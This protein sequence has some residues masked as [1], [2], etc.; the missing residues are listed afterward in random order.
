MKSKTEIMVSASHLNIEYN[1]HY[2]CTVEFRT[3]GAV[4]PLFTLNDGYHVASIERFTD[5]QKVAILKLYPPRYIQHLKEEFVGFYSR[6][7][8]RL[9]KITRDKINVE[10]FNGYYE[11]SC[12][13]YGKYY[14]Q[15]YS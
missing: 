1:G 6:F 11:L 13:Y 15:C 7:D 4:W 5:S 10:F 12:T 14:F 8:K 3:D 2:I 9:K